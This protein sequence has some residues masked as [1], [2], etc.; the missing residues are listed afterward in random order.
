MVVSGIYE[1]PPEAQE[2]DAADGNPTNN[3]IKHKP[4]FVVDVAVEEETGV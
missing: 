1:I 3:N 4:K 2:P